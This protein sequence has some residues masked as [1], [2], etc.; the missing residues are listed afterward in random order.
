[1]RKKVT[2]VR[3]DNCNVKINKAKDVH[4]VTIEYRH[5]DGSKEISNYE[6][7]P[8]CSAILKVLLDKMRSND[9][10][11]TEGFDDSIGIFMRLSRTS[12]N[13]SNCR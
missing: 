11:I 9:L 13:L 2:V 1:M 8:V 7:C 3:C 10:Y 6:L 5:P 12:V 4:N